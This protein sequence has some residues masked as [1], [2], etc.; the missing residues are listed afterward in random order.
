MQQGWIALNRSVLDH[1]VHNEKPFCI[2][3]AWVDLI[4][5]ANHEEKK[6]PLNGDIIQIKRGQMFTSYRSLSERWG[7]GIGRVK[8]FLKMLEQDE[9]I[10]TKSSKNGTLLTLVNYSN[11][12][13]VRNDNGTITE[14][15][16]N[17]NGTITERNNNINNDNNENND[18]KTR[19]GAEI[20]EIISYLNEKTGRKYTGRSKSTVKS[21]T[22]RLKEGFTVEEFK[23]V[24]DNKVAAW[25]R[26]A[27]MCQFLRPETLFDGRF[28]TYLN[29]TETKAQKAQRE[30]DE[31]H[32]RQT[33]AVDY[34]WLWNNKT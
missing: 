33:T 5:M 34:D 29:D 30:K 28:E 4:L 6:M 21:I 13:N 19:Y 15:K 22:A 23:Q 12:Q 10:T 7:W 11:F 18:N 20:S 2:F 27:K 14:H 24:I 9:M 1:W 26:D 31:L 32:E 3:G 25:A 17:D 8:R 16:R